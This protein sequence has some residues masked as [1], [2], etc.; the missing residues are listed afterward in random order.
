MRVLLAIV[1]ISMGGISASAQKN[2]TALLD[3]LIDKLESNPPT[4]KA[5]Y[6]GET[7]KAL[8]KEDHAIQALRLHKLVPASQDGVAWDLAPRA[9]A[10]RRAQGLPM[11]IEYLASQP[12]VPHT[13]LAELWLESGDLDKAAHHIKAAADAVPPFGHPPFQTFKIAR[14]LISAGREDDAN[15][16]ILPVM[17][18]LYSLMPKPNDTSSPDYSLT[19]GMR[20]LV[21]EHLDDHA[22][23]L[24]QAGQASNYRS[25][26][27]GNRVSFADELAMEACTALA[28]AGDEQRCAEWF[29][30]IS[31][32]YQ[33]DPKR[34]TNDLLRPIIKV[35]PLGGTSVLDVVKARDPVL[36]FRT[37]LWNCAL[38][39]LQFDDL[40]GVMSLED[41]EGTAELRIQASA[42]MRDATYYKSIDGNPSDVYDDYLG[43][44]EYAIEEGMSKRRIG[45]CIMMSEPWRPASMTIKQVCDLY[46]CRMGWDMDDAWQVASQFGKFAP[47]LQP[48][49]FAMFALRS[50]RNGDMEGMLRAVR[51]CEELLRAG[52]VPTWA[53]T[54]LVPRNGDQNVGFAESAHVLISLAIASAHHDRVSIVQPRVNA[55]IEELWENDGEWHGLECIKLIETLVHHGH[56]ELAQYAVCRLPIGQNDSTDPSYCLVRQL[57]A[58]SRF[59]D[60]AS[61]ILNLHQNI[62]HGY[63]TKERAKDKLG[64]NSITDGMKRK[65]MAHLVLQ[66]AVNGELTG[67]RAHKPMLGDEKWSEIMGDAWAEAIASGRDS[68]VT[69]EVELP[70]NV[71]G[72]A[73]LKAIE[74]V[75]SK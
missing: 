72:N 47:E 6:I 28:N 74:Q 34:L 32:D 14:V 21:L 52:V 37:Y 56:V 18:H 25:W 58:E 10:I 8:T 71:R 1:A 51:Q 48:T 43:L 65:L 12:K 22:I 40:S 7:I 73:I 33:F 26:S 19:W 29:G 9:Y 66:M 68:A 5:H 75:V 41:R 24:W 27:L 46:V 4:G 64:Y 36:H 23:K 50:A 20:E 35:T 16:L 57:I 53:R 61:V 13:L 70:P 2:D 63:S 11:A 38:G 62:V 3:E 67:A 69:I 59:T 31:M 54:F 15:E 55:V 39:G 49:A 45:A 60:A 42:Q 30:R 44:A 17:D